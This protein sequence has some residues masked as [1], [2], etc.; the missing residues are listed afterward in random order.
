LIE[1]LS[2]NILV[3]LSTYKTAPELVHSGK[4][5]NCKEKKYLDKI[6]AKKKIMNL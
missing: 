5:D 4:N 3:F 2:E 6:T 1:F